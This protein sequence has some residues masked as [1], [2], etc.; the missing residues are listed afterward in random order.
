MPGQMILDNGWVLPVNVKDISST[1]AGI[2]LLGETLK[3]NY[4][5]S[6]GYM[7]LNLIFGNG[8]KVRY[9]AKVVR[10]TEDGFVG[11]EFSES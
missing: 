8:E 4:N 1:G 9:K 3:F 7:I 2:Q 6:S 11:I 5:T 10:S